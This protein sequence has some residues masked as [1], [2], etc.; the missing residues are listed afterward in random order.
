MAKT[1]TVYSTKGQNTQKVETEANTWGELKKDLT[2]AGVE[3]SGMKA[4]IGETKTVLELENAVLPKGLTIG[5]VVTDNFC[6]FLSAAKQKA[7][8]INSESASY[9]ELKSFIK[10]ERAKSE[11]NSKLFGDYTHSTTEGLRKLVKKYQSKSVGS[12][13]SVTSQPKSSSTSVNDVVTLLDNAIAK[14]KTLDGYVDNSEAQ[15]LHQKAM[16]IEY[17][18]NNVGE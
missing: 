14:I 7:G 17:E 10:T 4:I 16:E 3:Y 18:L 9:G 1:V 8:L 15:A 6:L 5:G 13:S 2:K 12:S 11:A